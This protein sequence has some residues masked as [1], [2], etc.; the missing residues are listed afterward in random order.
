M[1]GTWEASR[2]LLDVVQS[3]LYVWYSGTMRIL[4]I[5]CVDLSYYSFNHLRALG[6]VL[7][8]RLKRG[9][10]ELI[11]LDLAAYRAAAAGEPNTRDI[12]RLREACKLAGV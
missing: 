11:G 12:I 7:V 5:D 2:F 10:V 3:L 4:P 8:D 6:E 1:S 9:K